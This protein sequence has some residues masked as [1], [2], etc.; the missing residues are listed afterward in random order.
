MFVKQ[1]ENISKPRPVSGASHGGRNQREGKR[2]T[3][4]LAVLGVTAAVLPIVGTGHRPSPITPPS[5]VTSSGSV[6]TR[7]S[8]A[9][10]SRHGD[11]LGDAGFNNAGAFNRLVTF[12]ATADANGRSAYTN[13][14]TT[15]VPSVALNPTDVLRAGTIP[16][17][18]VS[19]SGNAITALLADTASPKT[20]NF[21]FSA[22]EPTAAQQATAAS[23]GWGY[24]HVVEIGTD[25][26]H[27][28]ADSTATNVPSGRS[29][30]RRS[31]WAS[32]PAP[33][34]SGTSCPATPAGRRDT[35]V[36]D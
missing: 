7:P 14:V 10:R 6:A 30:G 34:P 15:G 33:T 32:T 26:V 28:A 11:Y 22:S 5:P 16:V 13:S 35:I 27:I 19:S 3:V 20:I 36:P 1:R 24:L 4:R 2:T 21:I 23:N 18:R 17:Q 31:S 8:I 29:V 12:N 25:S 9:R